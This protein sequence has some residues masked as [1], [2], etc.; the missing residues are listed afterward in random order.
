MKRATASGPKPAKPARK[1]SRFRRMVIQARPGL[2]AVEDQLFPEGTGMVAEPYGGGPQAGVPGA[3][4]FRGLLKVQLSLCRRRA[5]R[6]RQAL[7]SIIRC[8][9][10]RATDA[11]SRGGS[12][13]N[14]TEQER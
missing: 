4:I 14:C 10:D 2:E 6:E 13:N 8:H 12:Q 7:Q 5:C 3:A 11:I 1:A 9:A